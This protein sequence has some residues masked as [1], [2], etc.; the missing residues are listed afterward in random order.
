MIYSL[1]K[2]FIVISAVSVC[3]VFSIIF[4]IVYFVSISQ[5]NRSM[6]M[7][8][9]IISSN[10]G[11]FPAYDIIRNSRVPF[12]MRKKEFFTP[13][14][15]FS[16][17]FFTVWTDDSNTVLR[18]D[19]K[20]ISSVEKE[21]AE[22]YAAKALR[23]GTERGWISDYRYKVCVTERGDKSVVFVNGE[24]NRNTTF[25]LL[26]LVC[27]V[28]VGSLL[29]ILL[30]ILLISK[31][32]VIP[33]A[34]SYEK[35]KQFVTDANLELKTPLTLIL[36]NVDIVEG[37]IGRNEWLEDIRIEGN[38]MSVLINQLVALSRMDEDAGNLSAAEFD[39]SGTVSDTVSEF[40]GFVV[41][42][43]KRITVS[44]EPLISYIGDENLIRK[45][46]SIL[47][48][49]A[50]KYCD[51]EG[52]IDVT[53]FTKGNHPV[54]LV[55]NTYRDVAKVELDRLFDRFYRADKARTYTGSFGIGLSI[56]KGIAKKHKG[57]II[58][59]KKDSTHIGFKVIL[60]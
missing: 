13:D 59:Y 45:L 54:L 33:V 50:I 35:Q 48:D 40:E 29:I 5:L 52:Q 14:T 6:D 46:V 47:M 60:K 27:T 41:R 51:Q 26:Y 34:E 4:C 38:R 37:E 10:E 8:T 56:A 3:L 1:R 30:L 55:E 23:S 20:Q 19:V 43:D 57:D 53:V 12:E 11:K 49:N 17:R 58:A 9:D 16:T 42:N 18:T 36:S 25:R 24:M 32:A 28:M 21:E 15:Q 22:Q 2:K 7:L 44:I 39:L 31:Y